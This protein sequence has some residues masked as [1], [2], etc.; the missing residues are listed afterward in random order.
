MRL[1]LTTDDGEVIDIWDVGD[2]DADTI[3]SVYAIFGTSNLPAVVIAA[4]AAEEA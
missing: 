2:I 4:L 1:T 3:A